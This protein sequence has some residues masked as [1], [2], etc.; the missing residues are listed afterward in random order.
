MKH[1][2]LPLS[3]ETHKKLKLHCVEQGEKMT[4]VVRKLVEEYLGRVEKRKPKH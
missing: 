2:N 4:D 1:L 3:D